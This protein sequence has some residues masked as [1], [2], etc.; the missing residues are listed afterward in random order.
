M[1]LSEYRR[2]IDETDAQLVALLNQRAELVIA[3]A[4]LKHAQGLPVRIPARE[5]EVLTQVTAHNTGPLDHQAMRRLFEQII[6][7][8]RRLEH[9]ILGTSEDSPPKS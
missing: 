1:T 2:L 4:R 9:H 3:I 8:S 6:A 7:E 5:D